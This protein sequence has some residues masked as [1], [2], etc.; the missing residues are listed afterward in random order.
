VIYAIVIL[1]TCNEEAED[2]R[3]RKKKVKKERKKEEK[4]NSV[5]L[6]V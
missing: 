6:Y 4:T 1:C 3:L 2:V 5:V